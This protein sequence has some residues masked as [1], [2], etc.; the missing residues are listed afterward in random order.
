MG[1]FLPL[2]LCL[3]SRSAFFAAEACLPNLRVDPGK[4]SHEEVQDAIESRWETLCENRI[5]RDVGYKGW[6][7]SG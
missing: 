3:S 2:S 7:T 6:L 5:L 1:P 4:R